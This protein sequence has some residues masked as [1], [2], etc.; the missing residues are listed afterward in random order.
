LKKNHIPKCLVPLE[1]LFE[2]NDVSKKFLIQSQEK[3][4]VDYNIGTDT[5]SKIIKISKAL[6]EEKRR[7]YVNLMKEFV[8]V[9]VWSYE[10]LNIFDT[11]I[12]QHKIP[13][14]AGSKP[15]RQ[16]MRQFNSML[17]PIIEKEV[18]K[19]LDANIILPYRYS[20]W[21][22]NLVPVRKN[23]GEIRLCVD[24]RNM[25][26]CSLKDNYPLPKMYYI[27]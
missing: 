2:N 16:K 19:M 24:F 11:K 27:M 13:L 26:R 17:L 25:N 9:F 6:Y 4:A 10:D 14:K 23:N 8:D 3:D 20:E 7:R 5:N 18:K 22:A 21:V 15:F 12:I 1:R